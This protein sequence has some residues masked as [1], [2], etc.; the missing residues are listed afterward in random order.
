MR[1]KCEYQTHEIPVSYNFLFLSLIKEALKKS[2]EEYFA[3]MYQF[4]D[5]IANK[6][7]KN[8]SYAVFVQDYR[9][10]NEK[11]K[12]NGKVILNISSP[13][14]EFI[15]NLYNGLLKIYEFN[16]KKQFVL[17]KLKISLIKEKQILKNQVTFKTLSPICIKNKDNYFMQI[18]QKNYIDELNYIADIQLKNYRGAGL[19]KRIQFIPIKLKKVVVKQEIREFEEKTKKKYMYI[20]SYKGTFK[21]IGD[22]LDLRDLYTL[23]LGFKRNQGFGM[24]EVI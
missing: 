18:E 2:N 21:L 10:E 24:L 9:L 13:D 22:V 11:F 4:G 1:L 7:S 6:K 3:N 5:K 16:Y 15:I 12:V 23:G 14:T 8:F 20:N 19:R 17:N